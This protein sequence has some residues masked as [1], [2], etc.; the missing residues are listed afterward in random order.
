MNHNRLVRVSVG[1]WLML[2]AGSSPAGMVFDTPIS[3]PARS[4]EP[5]AWHWG[6]DE[7]LVELL[8]RAP[9]E[10]GDGV[11]PVAAGEGAEALEDLRPDL[12]GEDGDWATASLGSPLDL[13][14]LTVAWE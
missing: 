3:D 5:V 8:A 1:T 6:S 7:L 9:D 11:I 13:D 14:A 12:D 4:A 10:A 2:A